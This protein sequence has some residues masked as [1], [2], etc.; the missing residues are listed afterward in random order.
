MLKLPSVTTPNGENNPSNSLAVM[1]VDN[2]TNKM[3]NQGPIYKSIDDGYTY[4]RL[5]RETTADEELRAQ[6]FCHNRAPPNAVYH[7]LGYRCLA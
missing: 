2:P 7:V 6:S 4:E 5:E 3:R 1:Q